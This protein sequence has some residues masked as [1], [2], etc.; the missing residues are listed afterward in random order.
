M[1]RLRFARTICGGNYVVAHGFDAWWFNHKP[2]KNSPRFL[3][4]PVNTLSPKLNLRLKPWALSMGPGP[5]EILKYLPYTL[6]VPLMV[7]KIP[8][9]GP[10]AHIRCSYS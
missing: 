5:D 10:R 8:T 6:Y 2:S 4:R 1:F 9:K 7:L 3:K